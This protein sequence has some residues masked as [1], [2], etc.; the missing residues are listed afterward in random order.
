MGNHELIT[1]LLQTA[2][3]PSDAIRNMDDRLHSRIDNIT[4]TLDG[5]HTDDKSP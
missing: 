3:G 2:V 5:P 4:A 1:L